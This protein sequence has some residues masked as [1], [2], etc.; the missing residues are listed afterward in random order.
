MK[1]LQ[2][3]EH[4][5][6]LKAVLKLKYLREPLFRTAKDTS[7][8]PE[9]KRCYEL[10]EGTSRSFSAVIMELHPELRNSVMLFYL[11]LRALD[12]VEDDMTINPKIKVPLLRNFWKKLELT[13]WNFT[14]NSEQEKD[15]PV[16]LE[17]TNILKEYHKLKPDYQLVIKDITNKMGNG[18]ADYVLDEQFNL[19]GL[20]T[21]A[22]YDLYC[23]YVAGLVGDGLTRLIVL[24]NF[25]SHDLY[26]ES[27]SL[28]ESMGLFLQKTNIIRDYAEDLDDGRSFWPREIWSQYV[29]ELA[30]LAKPEYLD[31]GVYCINHLVL[32][33]LSHVQDVLTYLSSIHEQ[34]SFQFCAIPQV[35]AIA[36]LALVFG[37]KKV[38]QTNIKIRK[39]TTCYLILKSRTF[40]GCVE[41]FEYYLR[42]IRKRI[43]VDDPNYLKM[44]MQIARLDQF[45]EE[46][47]QNHLPESV[48][49]QETAIYQR[50]QER[51]AYDLEML[52]VLQEEEFKFNMLLSMFLT[53]IAALNYY[54]GGWVR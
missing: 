19:N 28:F 37:N 34:S 45:I 22:D 33:A 6:E 25:G 12:T 21:V 51:S 32:N 3:F 20:E 48:K 41:I 11:I 10:L 23:H 40:R 35:M 9:L 49:P 50:V 18:M 14:G 44:N 31:E 24:A 1:I 8:T 4:P 13:E 2:L 27:E 30:D 46:M 38:L 26:D 43:T 15:R 52:P 53:L 47:Y 29:D 54:F 39:G 36:T 17:F 5:L 16:L 42:D 7:E